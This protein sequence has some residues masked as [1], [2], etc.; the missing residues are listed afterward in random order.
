MSSLVTAPAKTTPPMRG[1]CGDA[2]RLRARAD[3]VE[4][5][6]VGAAE[7]DLERQVAGAAGERAVDDLA[8]ERRVRRRARRDRERCRCRRGGACSPSSSAGRTLAGVAAAGIGLSPRNT[9]MPAA[10]V[11]VKSL[12]WKSTSRMMLPSATAVSIVRLDV[13][14]HA[15]ERAEHHAELVVDGAVAVE[16]EA[17][18]ARL[19]VR[20][21]DEHLVGDVVIVRALGND[22]A[23]SSPPQATKRHRNEAAASKNGRKAM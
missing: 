5:D 14:A 9:W 18:L 19:R 16:V 11:F 8:A 15:G 1:R 2:R 17:V 4:L 13:E 3:Q 23:S 22:G 21:R 20:R 10:V 6:R 12:V 7:R